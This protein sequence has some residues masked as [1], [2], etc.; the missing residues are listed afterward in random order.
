MPK[1]TVSYINFTLWRSSVWEHSIGDS[2]ITHLV[3][4]VLRHK[5]PSVGGKA[6]E[7][8]MTSSINQGHLGLKLVLVPPY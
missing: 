8:V 7:L 5:S 4:D 1:Y 2:D 6:D 3:F